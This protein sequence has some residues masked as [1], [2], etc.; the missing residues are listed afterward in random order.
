MAK[1]PSHVL[2]TVKFLQHLP[3][4]NCLDA[5]NYTQNSLIDFSLFI[6]MLHNYKFETLQFFYFIF[7]SFFID[8]N[9]LKN[10]IGNL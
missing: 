7:K 6:E 8:S 10:Y 4:H 5:K 1:F 3:V 9:L 2:I